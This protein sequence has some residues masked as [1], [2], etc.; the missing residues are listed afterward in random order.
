MLKLF[1]SQYTKKIQI[2]FN[3]ININSLRNKFEL[4]A[5]QF[6]GNIDVLMI[7]ETKFDDSFPLGNF[8]LGGFSK[9]YRL[10]RDSLGGVV[11]LYVW[12]N[13]PTNLTGVETK[14]LKVFM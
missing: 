11:L 8:L 4:L 1:W 3:N 6:K 14:T 13:I 2:S 5:D 7:S 9:T 10:D 12:E